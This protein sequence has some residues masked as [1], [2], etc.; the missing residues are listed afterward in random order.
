MGSL[1]EA[2]MTSTATPQQDALVHDVLSAR[3]ELSTWN[4]IEY[5]CGLLPC[6]P[7]RF[8]GLSGAHDLL[9][10]ASIQLDGDRVTPGEHEKYE[11]LCQGIVDNTLAQLLNSGIIATFLLAHCFPVQLADVSN[12]QFIPSLDGAWT[13]VLQTMQFVCSNL[14]MVL[15]LTILFIGANLYTQIA[16]WMPDLEGKLWCMK[17]HARMRMVLAWGFMWLFACLAISN[18]CSALCGASYL[19]LVSI[20][21]L[22]TIVALIFWD[23]RQRAECTRYLF[24][25]VQR[26]QGKSE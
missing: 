16:F 3:R 10:L 6:T 12:P 9:V 23:L 1:S 24:S 13:N 25:R 17:K 4:Q 7:K 11:K 20:L 2:L 21:P 8:G 5:D 15:S 14:I 19:G 26:V 18:L 22:A